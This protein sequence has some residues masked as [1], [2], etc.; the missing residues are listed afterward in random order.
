MYSLPFSIK[1]NEKE[2]GNGRVTHEI[3]KRCD[4]ISLSGNYDLISSLH[5]YYKYKHYKLLSIPSIIL[6]YDG[7][8]IIRKYKPLKVHLQI[9]MKRE[10]LKCRIREL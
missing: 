3:R 2:N 8:G 1:L 5:Y 9:R 6:I 4:L 7:N 10:D